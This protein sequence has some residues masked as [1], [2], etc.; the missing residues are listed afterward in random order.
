MS[1]RLILIT[2]LLAIF[3]FSAAAVFMSIPGVHASGGGPSTVATSTSNAAARYS[4]QDKSFYADGLFWVFYS[5]G[6]NL[7]YSTSSTGTSWTVGASSPIRACTAGNDFSIWFDGT[8]VY[9]AYTANSVDTAMYYRVGTP[10]S[11]GSIT[12]IAAEQTAIAAVSSVTYSN[13]YVSVDSAGHAWI[14]YDYYTTSITPYVTESASTASGAGGGTWG[15]TPSGFPHQLSS[16]AESGWMSATIPLTSGN[17]LVIYAGN[18]VYLYADEWSGTSWGTPITSAYEVAN[19]EFFGAVANGNNVNIAYTTSAYAIQYMQYIY[20][21]NSFSAGAT[22][23]SG[24]SANYA[25]VISM[26]PVTGNL[27]VFW[28]GYPTANHIYYSEYSGSSWSSPVSWI[29]ESTSLTATYDLTCFY[30]AYGTYMGVEYMTATSSP[31]NVRFAFLQMA[32]TSQLSDSGITYSTTIGGTS[33]TF[34]ITASDTVALN[35]DGQYEFGTNITGSMVWTTPVNFTRTLSQTVTETQTLPASGNT[36]AFAWDLSDNAGN[37]LDT[38]TTRFLVVPATFSFAEAGITSASPDT[39]DQKPAVING[40]NYI[41]ASTGGSF[42]ETH[43]SVYS[44]TSSWAPSTELATTSTSGW[45]DFYVF[46]Y[47]SVLPN[48]I[49]I[50]GNYQADM[51]GFIMEFNT[52]SNTFTNSEIVT[53][54]GYVTQVYYISNLNEFVITEA[55]S[56][57]SESTYT[58]YIVTCAP[59]NLFN[60]ANWAVSSQAYYDAE[61]P[62]GH[63][64][65]FCYDA[66][67]GYGYFTTYASATQEEIW[68][69]NMQTWAGSVIWSSAV[70]KTIPVGTYIS[71]DG[72]NVYF[73]AYTQN[74]ADWDYYVYNGYTFTM[75]ASLPVIND[76]QAEYSECHADIFP[77]GNG[78]VLIG[79]TCDTDT[80]GYYAI[81]QNLVQ[82]A[83]FVGPD[84]HFSDNHLVVDSLGNIVIGGEDDTGGIQAELTVITPSNILTNTITAS[85]DGG[86]TISPSGSVNSPSGSTQTFTISPDSGYTISEVVVNDMNQGALTSYT[87]PDVSGSATISVISEAEATVSI[88][89]TSSPATGSGFI[90]INGVAETTPYT[91]SAAIVGATYAIATNSPANTVSDQ[92]QYT[93]VQWSSTSIGTQTSQSYTYTVPAVGETVTAS[94]QLQYYLTV[95]GGNGVTYGTAPTEG[96]WYNSGISTTVSSNGVYGRS[97]GTGQRVAS[98]NIDGGSNTDVATAGTVTTSSVSMSTYHTVN[99]NSV[100]QYQVTLDAGATAAL[101]SIT[102]ATVSGDNYWYDSGTSVTLTLNGVYGR[103]DG[104]GTRV[105]GYNVNAGSNNPE[106]TTSTFT[107]LNAVSI[108]GIE[109]I[110]TTTVTQYQVTLDSGATSA[111]SS[112]TSPTISGDNYWYDSGTSVSLVLNGVY[113]RSGGSGTRVSG[114]EINAGSNNP[115]T[116]VSSFTVFAMLSLFRQ[117]KPSRQRQ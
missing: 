34:S 16:T 73:S 42:Q 76:G 63:E 94:F 43:I 15:T 26:D 78:L 59:S 102:S 33:C 49:I 89:F 39:D 109:A 70:T 47:P 61:V 82:I 74:A 64:H 115:E 103:S 111:L 87:F 14:S 107:V 65:R 75:F 22:L 104:S 9:Y 105:S 116:T 100:T 36:V 23:E 29:T 28:A 35:P 81:Y 91:I 113:G 50:C 32:P 7:A 71:S 10:T 85:N 66:G 51:Y 106:S 114:Y 8:Y 11:S 18:G 19:S 30:E 84:T 31:Y 38:G 96:N 101:S 110:T 83:S 2:F 27:Y 6:T 21:S 67:T 17:M 56:G 24:A 117:Y 37:T 112:I 62:Q 1:T 4:Y 13:P 72:V 97:S 95:N 3:L 53:D 58:N 86:S 99:F 88:T 80:S 54:T 92:S 44:A 41:V 108:N 57:S 90:T 48:T 79:D 69:I 77:L 52:V 12:W 45:G 93:F 60:Q 55:P 98:W 46:T 20:S 25:P 5:D 40:N 68:Q